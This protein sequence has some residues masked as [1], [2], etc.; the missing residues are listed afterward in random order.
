MTTRASYAGQ[1]IYRERAAYTSANAPQWGEFRCLGTV[2]ALG[3]PFAA[4][5][6]ELSAL[7]QRRGLWGAFSVLASGGISGKLLTQHPQDCREAMAWAI[8]VLRLMG[9]GPLP[10]TAKNS[11]IFARDICP[12]APLSATPPPSST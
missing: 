7:W 1:I 3:E 11:S 10:Y 8:D 9:A 6:E 4:R 12:A 2:L 5:A